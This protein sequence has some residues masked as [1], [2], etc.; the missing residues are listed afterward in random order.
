MSISRV[1]S[2]VWSV[3]KTKMTTQHISQH[4]VVFYYRTSALR[5][6]K[7]ALRFGRLSRSSSIDEDQKS[8][9]GTNG[10]YSG[11]E[12][13]TDALSTDVE[14]GLYD[15]YDNED[16]LDGQVNGDE[17]KRKPPRYLLQSLAGFSVSPFCVISSPYDNKGLTGL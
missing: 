11:L 16:D 15:D 10:R 6:V 12:D 14:A 3:H 1:V 2:V 4:T 9:M 17:G 5:N 13:S 7:N 8:L